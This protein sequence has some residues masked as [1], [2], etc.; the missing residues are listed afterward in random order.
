[1]QGQERGN[2]MGTDKALEEGMELSMRRGLRIRGREA[3][4]KV[5]NA[6]TKR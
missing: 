5:E 3:V 6:A 1:M 2:V 4:R